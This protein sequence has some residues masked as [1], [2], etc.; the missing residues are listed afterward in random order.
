MSAEK[1]ESSRG[2][3]KRSNAISIGEASPSGRSEKHG[4]DAPE[5]LGKKE[6]GQRPPR[7]VSTGDMPETLQ[8]RYFS[9]TSK[10]S[11]EPAYFTTA[12]AKEPAFRDQGRRL[13]TSSDSEEVVRD[14][15]AIARHR[16]WTNV[17]LTGSEAFRRAAWLEANRQGLDVRGY[18]PNERD[19][20]ELDRLKLGN[21]RNSIAPAAVPSVTRES[22]RDQSQ[23]HERSARSRAAASVGRNE[24]AAQSQLRVIEAVVRTAL[25]DNPEA[26][27]RVMKVATT[28]LQNHVDRGDQIRPALLREGRNRKGLDVAPNRN[29]SSRVHP[30]VQ[31]SRSR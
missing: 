20:Q 11:G 14:L 31:R 9:S 19:L 28:T 30:P 21:D 2:A 25:F 1:P 17:H 23:A 6:K 7:S 12:Q 8:K 24:R 26:I 4:P 18:R 3:R 13:V 5:P 15:V 22:G 29:E 10:W 27:S 16:G